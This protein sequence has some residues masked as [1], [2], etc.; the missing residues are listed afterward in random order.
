VNAA[1]VAQISKGV[2]LQTNC[3]SAPALLE[4]T[5]KIGA[6]LPP[7]FDKEYQVLFANS[8]KRKG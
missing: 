6:I 4:L 2:H 3:V 8:G 5:E 7:G 1:A